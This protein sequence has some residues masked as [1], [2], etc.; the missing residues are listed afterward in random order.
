[1][2]ILPTAAGV[3]FCVRFYTVPK[4]PDAHIMVNNFHKH[5]AISMLTELFVQ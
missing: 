4:K 5:R 3:L 1:M 2:N